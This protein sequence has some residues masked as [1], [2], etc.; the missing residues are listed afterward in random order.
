[1]TSV[2]SL[3][4]QRHESVRLKGQGGGGLGWGTTPEA[5][6]LFQPCFARTLACRA[7]VVRCLFLILF[8][9]GGEA[10]AAGVGRCCA[11]QPLVGTLRRCTREALAVPLLPG[12]RMTAAQGV[13]PHICKKGPTK[14]PPVLRSASPCAPKSP[15]L[16]LS[17]FWCALSFFR[18]ALDAAA[19]AAALAKP[20]T[21]QVRWPNMVQV[22]W[23]CCCPH[24][25]LGASLA[26]VGLQQLCCGVCL[27]CALR[28]HLILGRGAFH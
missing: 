24:C 21:V 8:S 15:R 14:R 20:N 16:T 11:M 12:R 2:E 28:A 27:C 6:P 13:G 3:L 18:R 26:H 7:S 4:S 17:H 1:M 23:C 9:R 10:H 22:R 25:P 19:E 5:T